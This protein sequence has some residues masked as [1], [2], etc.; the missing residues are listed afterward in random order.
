M[1]VPRF[2]SP[3]VVAFEKKPDRDRNG[4]IRLLKAV[5]SKNATAVELLHRTIIGSR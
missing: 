5:V 1:Q 4:I 2:D 3:M